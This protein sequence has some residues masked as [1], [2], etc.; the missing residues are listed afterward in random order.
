VV[1]LT[2]LN[3]A[4]DFTFSYDPAGR[5][6]NEAADTAPTGYLPFLD[7]MERDTGLKIARRMYPRRIMVIDRAE[8]APVEK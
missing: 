8:R 4:Y 6:T 5:I 7:A 2:R 1:D 3:G